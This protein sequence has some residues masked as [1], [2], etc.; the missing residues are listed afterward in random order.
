M[1]QEHTKY[2]QIQDESQDP[3]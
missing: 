3:R 2:T 1:K